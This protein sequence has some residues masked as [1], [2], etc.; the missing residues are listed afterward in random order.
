[1]PLRWIK[2]QFMNKKYNNVCPIVVQRF[3]HDSVCTLS[4]ICFDDMV[5]YGLEPATPIVEDGIY[6]LTLTRSPRFSGKYPYN[7]LHDS[8][9]PLIN[10]VHGHSGVRIHVGNYPSDTDGCLLIGCSCS[11]ALLKDSVRAYRT[12]LNR[13]SEIEKVNPNVFY[14]IQF[15]SCYE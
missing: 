8:N 15:V 12:L 3:S 7:K 11:L 9:V 2:S 6:L 4:R 5:F 1:M 14:L 10:G 13:M